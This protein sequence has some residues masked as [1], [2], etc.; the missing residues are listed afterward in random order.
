MN[1][2]FVTPHKFE[3]MPE[4]E[5]RTLCRTCG[6]VKDR[7]VHL[8]IAHLAWIRRTLKRQGFEDG[9]PTP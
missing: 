1:D 4:E 2:W 9:G 3:R 6:Q 7:A 8:G 5:F